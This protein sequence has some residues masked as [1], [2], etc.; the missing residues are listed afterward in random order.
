M[1]IE[2]SLFRHVLGRFAS[3]VTVVTMAYAGE[4]SGLTVSAF[5]SVSL[6]PPLILICIDKQSSTLGL[7]RN[8]QAFVVNVLS[9]EQ[10]A[11]S[12]HFA[13]KS[14][15][16][17]AGIP[18]H[19]GRLGAPVLS[20]TLA[21]MECK[22]VSEVDGGDHF[23]YIGQIEEAAYDEEKLPLLY[24]HGSYGTFHKQV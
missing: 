1:P 4:S 12:N 17:L 24:Y 2:G 11:L 7:L 15:E 23:V 19:T 10:S 16:K 22:L 3:G 21:H 8:S 5:S 9:A 6:A 13:S 20:H 18:H 14:A